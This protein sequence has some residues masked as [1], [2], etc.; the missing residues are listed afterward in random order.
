MTASTTQSLSAYRQAF[1]KFNHFMLW[2][3]RLGFRRWINIWPKVIGRIM[4]I[5]HTGRKSGLRRQTPVNYS[6]IDGDIYCTAGFGH[7][8]DWYRNI[9]AN[10][11]VE[12]WLPDSWWAGLAEEA[13][14]SENRLTALRQVLKD[15]GF[16]APMFGVNP[17]QLSEQEFEQATT[18][19]RLIRIRRTQKLSG[20]G[21]PGDLAWVWL[22]PL[23]ICIVV[24]IRQFL[25]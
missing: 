21:G 19:Y 23:L 11:Q 6:I 7:V 15:S 25:K 16:A 12:V 22:F 8:S 14:S 4:V 1:K 9:L 13:D 3:W 17:H 18:D 20:R 2:M 10:P 24:L 5:T